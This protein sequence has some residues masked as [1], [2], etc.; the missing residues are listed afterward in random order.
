M[1]CSHLIV[2]YIPITLA[3]LTWPTTTRAYE[4]NA[5]RALADAPA[6]YWAHQSIF[7]SLLSH[8]IIHTKGPATHTPQSC[9]AQCWHFQNSFSPS[10]CPPL[11]PF[12]PL[13]PIP[14]LPDFHHTGQHAACRGCG[15][16]LVVGAFS[17]SNFS[18][19]PIQ[20][21]AH[22]PFFPL[23]PCASSYP[24]ECTLGLRLGEISFQQCFHDRVKRA[25]EWG[26]CGSWIV[27]S[28]HLVF[29][30]SRGWA[31]PPDPFLLPVISF[32]LPLLSIYK[33][34]WNC[35]TARIW[36]DLLPSDISGNFISY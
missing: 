2:F 22:F 23:L 1:T 17:F 7:V 4:P 29:M 19:H 21:W 34:G 5:L 8:C 15:W 12:I 25:C 13:D 36:P 16:W 27:W 6:T 31:E 18:I 14:F 28:A 26:V 20:S 11:S 35:S 33:R 24:S 32:G 30:H 3:N 9:Y 10:R